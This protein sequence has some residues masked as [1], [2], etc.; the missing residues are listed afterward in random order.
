MEHKWI[1]L[2]D[3]IGSNPNIQINERDENGNTFLI[4]AA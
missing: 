3:L 2:E 4:M 1:E